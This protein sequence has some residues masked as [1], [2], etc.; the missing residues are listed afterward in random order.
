MA[1]GG[2]TRKPKTFG[3]ILGATF[4]AAA[5]V[6][7]IFVILTRRRSGRARPNKEAER[8]ERERVEI[9]RRYGP[10]GEVIGEGVGVVDERTGGRRGGVGTGG[11]E[12]RVGEGRGISGE[13]GEIEEVGG[14]GIGSERREMGSGR[15]GR[16]LSP[17]MGTTIDLA[18]G[19]RDVERNIGIS[20][21]DRGMR[22]DIERERQIEEER[23]RERVLAR[24]RE[25][26]RDQAIT[27]NSHRDGE[28]VEQDIVDQSDLPP[29]YHVVIAQAP[30]PVYVAGTGH[31]GGNSVGRS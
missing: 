31:G 8:L 18:D 14:G 25:R 3:I 9:G 5:V 21:V 20:S 29:A 15:E 6:Y 27:N 2:R 16:E 23:E 11:F 19:R 30:V 10:G 22:S 4:G 1:T 24:Q 17:W 7:V 28:M 12:R 26:E 13:R